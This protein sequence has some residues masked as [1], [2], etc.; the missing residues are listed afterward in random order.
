MTTP[1]VTRIVTISPSA[2][3]SVVGLTSEVR[4]QVVAS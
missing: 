3:A 4:Q 1:S 2:F